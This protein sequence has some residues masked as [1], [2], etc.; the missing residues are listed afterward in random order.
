MILL[1]ER[2]FLV[3]EATQNMKVVPL[4]AI[5]AEKKVV[6]VARRSL[7]RTRRRRLRGE[8]VERWRG[9]WGGVYG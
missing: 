2:R 5:T 1:D 9:M 3:S 4:D 6:I 8:G 7:L